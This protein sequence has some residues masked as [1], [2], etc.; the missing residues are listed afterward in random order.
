MPKIGSDADQ[1]DQSIMAAT[2]EQ[3][4][5]NIS[6]TTDPVVICGVQRKMNIGD[7]ETIDVYCSI[8]VPVPLADVTDFAEL[9]EKAIAAMERVIHIVSKETGD[10]YALIK[11][12]LP[13][14]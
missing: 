6:M 14:K 2:I 1:K 9:E 12:S 13:K 4:K 5:G 3:L 10:K 7:F 8:A 11:G